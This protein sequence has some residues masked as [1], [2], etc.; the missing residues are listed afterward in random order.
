MYSKQSYINSLKEAEDSQNKQLDSFY[1]QETLN[2]E[3]IDEMI[4][5]INAVTKDEVQQIARKVTKIPYI[6]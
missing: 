5:K 6:F 3:T 4:E 1:L 2:L